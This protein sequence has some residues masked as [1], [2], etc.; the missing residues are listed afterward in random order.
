MEGDSQLGSV[1]AL[2]KTIKNDSEHV[3]R[4]WATPRIYFRLLIEYLF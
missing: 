4:N 1:K 3:L 2:L